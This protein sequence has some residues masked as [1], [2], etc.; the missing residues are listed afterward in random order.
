VG[1]EGVLQLAIFS[2]NLRPRRD[3]ASCNG[4]RRGI[5]SGHLNHL[6]GVEL[7][8]IRKTKSEG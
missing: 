5:R 7:E 8:T 2:I 6:L 1:S 3:P 4:W